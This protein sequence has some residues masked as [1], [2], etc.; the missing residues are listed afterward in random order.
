MSIASKTSGAWSFNP[1]SR[2]GSDDG[3]GEAAEAVL[4]SI[5]TPV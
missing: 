4:V 3:M 5:H 1:H 2:I